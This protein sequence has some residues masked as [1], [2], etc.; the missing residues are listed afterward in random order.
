MLQAITFYV[1][2][3][4]MF[5]CGRKILIV[6][7]LQAISKRWN[8]V[9]DRARVAVASYYMRVIAPSLNNVIFVPAISVLLLWCS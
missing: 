3:S 8:G 2:F 9:L 4:E 6:A 5:Y 1:K 7:S